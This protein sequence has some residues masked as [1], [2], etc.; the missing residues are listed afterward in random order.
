MAK[1]RRR[2]RSLGAT[3]EKHVEALN[4]Y[5]DHSGT[6]YAE[7]NRA[8]KANDC[9]TMYS[10][11]LSLI[12]MAGMAD[13]A[14]LGIRTTGDRKY[15]WRQIKDRAQDAGGRTMTCLKR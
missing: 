11:M 6:V 14:F 8:A 10:K 9:L 4:H 13:E 5:Y 12:R 2:R 15:K 3:T 1:T 7:F